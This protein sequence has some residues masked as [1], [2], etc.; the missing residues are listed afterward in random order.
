VTAAGR[1]LAAGAAVDPSAGDG[2]PGTDK[3]SVPNRPRDG[4]IPALTGLRFVAAISVVLAH[5]TIQILRYEPPDAISLWVPR[6]SGFGMT[7]FFV[8]S[9]FVIHYNYRHLAT[10]RHWSGLASFLWARFARLYPLFLVM[11]VLDVLLGRKLVDFLTGNTAG[12]I[13][14]LRALPYYLLFVQ[15]WIYVPFADD[16]LIYVTA[17]NISLTWSISTEWFFYLAYPA[18]AL[19]VLRLRRPAIVLGTIVAWSLLW[20]SLASSLYAITPEIDSWA[21]GRYGPMAGVAAGYQDSFIRW[22]LYFSP[23][24]RIGEFIL[25]CLVAQLYLQRRSR[26]VAGWEREFGRWLLPA[27]IASVPLVIFLTY[28]QTW[29]SALLVSLSTN[30]ALAPSAALILFGAARYETGI[31]RFLRN[32]AIVALGEASYSIYLIHFLILLVIAGY[33]GQILPATTPNLIFL[34][35]RFAFV[36]ALICV[37]ALSLHGF[38]EVPARRWLRGLWSI[39][40]PRRVG[41]ALAIAAAPAVAALFCLPVAG[42]FAGGPDQITAGIRL[43]SATYGGNCGGKH[44]NATRALVAECNGKDACDYTVDVAKLGDPAGGCAKDFAVDYQCMPATAPREAAL[45]G[46]AGFGSHV[47]LAC[48]AGTEGSAQAA[49]AP[50]APTTA[51]AAAPADAIAILS[52]TYGQNC[53]VRRGNATADVQASCKGKSSCGYVVDVTRLGDPAN[54]CAKNFAVTYRCSGSPDALTRE[55]PAEAGFGTSLELSCP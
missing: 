20:G 41:A 10:A 23:Y 1:D 49:A 44:G 22:L 39:A 24:V 29:Q 30:F 13:D 53:G 37:L 51:A 26:L 32:P 18:I 38:V 40:G 45:P 31:S 27:A 48:S 11:L 12:F 55:A 46:E 5:G 15:S 3:V 36:L 34:A 14:V 9:G 4:A 21:V 7:L 54:G 16:S 28:S 35:L 50:P 17:S 33:L 19:V 47:V 8:L 43:I 25:G 2:L 42:F 52:A 6:L